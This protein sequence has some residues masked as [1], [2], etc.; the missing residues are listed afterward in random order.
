KGTTDI[1]FEFPFGV[2]ELQGV[3]A[4]GDFDLTQHSNVSGQK[5]DWFD[6]VAKT[7]Y[8]PHVI[9]PSVG[10]DRV[11]LALLTTAYHEDEIE[12]EKRIVLRLPARIAPFKAAIF[13]L[14]KNK[15]LRRCRS[16]WSPLPSPGRDRYA[17]RHH[18]RL[19]DDR[20]GRRRH[21]PRPR[22]AGAGPHDRR[23]GRPLPRR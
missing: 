13:P 12:G 23:R 20:E 7:R 15:F 17:L 14:V 18:N 10:V 3:A 1:M 19:R 21:G 16:H 22:H 11:F 9:E 4:R 5:L 8:I 6:E 2:Q